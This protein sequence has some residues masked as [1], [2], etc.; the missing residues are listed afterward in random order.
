MNDLRLESKHVAAARIDERFEPLDVVRVAGRRLVVPERLDARE[1]L[2]RIAPRT[3]PA[4][5]VEKPRTWC[6]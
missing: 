1:V 4:V 3:K 6:R 5:A 2:P